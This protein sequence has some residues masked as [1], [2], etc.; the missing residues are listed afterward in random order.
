MVMDASIRTLG[1]SDFE[2]SRDDTTTVYTQSATPNTITASLVSENAPLL[3]QKHRDGHPKHTI[4]AVKAEAWV[5][6]RYALP[7]FGTQLLEH[8]LMIASVIS[9]GHIS[10]E[11][12]AASTLGSMTANVTGL[13]I[14]HGFTSAL[15]SLLPQAWTSGRPQNV[16][17]WTQ[18]M[19][20]LMTLVLIPIL[21]VWL[22][23]EAILLNLGQEPGIAHLAGV[24]L[25]WFSLGLPG[26]AISIILRRFYQAQGLVHVPTV[27]MAVIAPINALLCWLL[28][29]GPES[30]N[31]GFIGA[32][33][34]SSLSFNL[35][36][37]ISLVYARWFIPDTALHPI[38][39]QCFREIGKLFRLG[40]SGVGQ[41]ASEWWSWEFVALAA[42]QLGPTSL[43]AQSVLLTS[44]STAFQTPYSL[45][46]ATTVRVGNL[47]GS[48][49][50][51]M[52]KL[53]AETAIGMSLI[54][55]LALSTLFMTFR[56][57][58]GYLFNDD[59]DVASLVASVLPLV[60][61]FQIVDGA[62]AVSDGVLRARGMLGLGAIINICSYYIVG[63]PAGI[64]L[65]FWAHLGLKGLWAG[66]AI[67]L[68][69]AAV[70]SIFVV[71]RTDWDLEVSKAQERLSE[72]HEDEAQV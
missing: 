60:A 38:N 1:A 5:L 72:E 25:R 43:A 12:L 10:T 61:L 20:V 44:C 3:P 51:Q 71:Y 16:G 58:W 35:M 67:A 54:V 63:L 32:P 50:A 17:L 23:A 69:C 13:S 11:A 46:M 66:L 52:A 29:W 9:I 4:S 49:H 2:N 59:K 27:I 31:T 45:G 8:S 48:G 30:V 36:A 57:D 22:N 64:A 19:S 47:L 53:A 55:A 28:V 15:D 18:R 21:A 56:T 37:I 40:I 34:A 26:Q 39:Q 62:T 41:I 6:C 33:I 24:Y 68:F 14:I 7:I 42:S 70:I 65:A